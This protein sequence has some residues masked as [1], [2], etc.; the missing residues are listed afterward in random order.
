[1]ESIKP[2]PSVTQTEEYLVPPSMENT[3]DTGQSIDIKTEETSVG[4]NEILQLSTSGRN[5]LML[6]PLGS[7]DELL[8]DIKCYDKSIRV[9][10]KGF[11]QLVDIDTLSTPSGRDKHIVHVG[12]CEPASIADTSFAGE[13]IGSHA[14]IEQPIRSQDSLDFVEQPFGSQ[15]AFES[16]EEPIRA[17]GAFESVEEPIR[18]QGAFDS[19]EQPIGAQVAFESVEEPIRAQEHLESVEQPTRNLPVSLSPASLNQQIKSSPL[20]QSSVKQTPVVSLGGF[21]QPIRYIRIQ[22]PASTVIPSQNTVAPL[23]SSLTNENTGLKLLGNES[24]LQEG[25]EN[26]NKEAG[27][28]TNTSAILD[29][30]NLVVSSN[31]YLKGVRYVK[32]KAPAKKSATRG[33]PHYR[34]PGVK[35][36]DTH[37]LGLLSPKLRALGSKYIKLD[38]ENHPL[39]Y[40]SPAARALGAK[41]D[42]P[43]LSTSNYNHNSDGQMHLAQRKSTLT[44]T[45]TSFNHP[46]E[47]AKTKL[48]SSCDITSTELTIEDNSPS[49]GPTFQ[50]L[51]NTMEATQTVSSVDDDG[52][53]PLETSI[54]C[55]E[56][57]VLPN[58]NSNS[59]IDD[60]EK[61]HSASSTSTNQL[62]RILPKPDSQSA[63][64]S[65]SANENAQ[66]PNSSA[67]FPQHLYHKP[68][69]V[70][71][72]SN[73][74][75]LFKKALKKPRTCKICHLLIN[76]TTHNCIRRGVYV[77]KNLI[78]T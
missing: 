33:L 5:T 2:N 47:I 46:S 20:D 3:N 9:T 52:V 31:Q 55:Q 78:I 27:P 77:C 23:G 22:T 15:G 59:V 73:S 71:Q 56:Q 63:S 25:R 57:R 21:K 44:E 74:P 64:S 28:Q 62:L 8:K 67:E 43:P 29:T 76:L 35:F 58:Y 7:D 50:R 4:D 66:R 42:P 24:L 36:D 65:G 13:P 41:N 53:D 72:S 34:Q 45:E 68:V 19:V 51:A 54:S 6:D 70:S 39:C 38:E 12:A 10:K 17:Q 1:M 32:L 61:I 26:V 16:V 75:R 60:S 14:G 11:A 48:V 18:A 49:S 37:P 30:G 69:K 40:L